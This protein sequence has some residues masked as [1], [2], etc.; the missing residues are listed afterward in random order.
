MSLI[1]SQGFILHISW[2]LD[3]EILSQSSILL[4]HTYISGNSSLIFESGFISHFLH[5]IRRSLSSR[6]KLGAI[7]Y[8]SDQIHIAI[9]KHSFESLGTLMED[10]Y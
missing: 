9:I 7:D 3:Q 4:L 10:P 8:L 2:E 1:M 6:T 5:L